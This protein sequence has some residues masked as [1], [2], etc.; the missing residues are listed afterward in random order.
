MSEAHQL[1]NDEVPARSAY[2]FQAD[3]LYQYV[4]QKPSVTEESSAAII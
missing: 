4:C 1:L 3:S 2:H